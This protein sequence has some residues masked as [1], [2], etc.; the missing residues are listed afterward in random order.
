MTLFGIYA[1]LIYPVPIEPFLLSYL[2]GGISFAYLAGR[3]KGI[4]I[5]KHGSGNLGASNVVRVLGKPIGITVFFLD[6]LKGL[7][8]TFYWSPFGYWWIFETFYGICVNRPPVSYAIAAGLGAILGHVFTPYHRFKGGKGV[9]TS[10]GVVLGLAPVAGGIAFLT[11]ALVTYLTRYISV[12]SMA[13]AVV[14]VCVYVGLNLETA[15]DANL[16]I[17]I[18][19]S[20]VAFLVMVKHRANIRR[21]IAGTE[22]K[23]GQKKSEATPPPPPPAV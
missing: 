15:F 2:I 18:F 23:I 9:A 11:W 1:S 14:V 10:L 6:L 8:P 20:L 17:T 5:R 22:N 3:M 4:D 19:L 7:L 16:P 13:A 21:L 12:G